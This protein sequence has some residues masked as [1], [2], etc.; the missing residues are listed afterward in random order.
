MVIE[1]SIIEVYY[2]RTEVFSLNYITMVSGG[3]RALK[4]KLEEIEDDNNHVSV[5]RLGV[6]DCAQYFV[7]MFAHH[8]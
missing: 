1:V 7:L 6:S 5:N 2:L 3:V 4:E 8:V